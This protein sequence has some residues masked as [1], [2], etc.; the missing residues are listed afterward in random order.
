MSIKNFSKRPVFLSL[1]IIFVFAFVVFV[2]NSA[3]VNEI[4]T[5]EAA[6]S[7]NETQNS[8]L[9]PTMTADN[10]DTLVTDVDG[11]GRVD[12]GDTIQYTVT[13]NNSAGVGVGNDALGVTFSET[14]SNDTTLVGGSLNASPI[15][16]NDT[17][18]V[19]GNLQIQV[20]DGANDVLANDFD[21]DTNSNAGLTASGGTTSAQGGNVTINANGSF[22]Y[23]PPPGFEGTDTFTYTVTD[24]GGATNTATIT[25]NVSG[26]IWFVNNNA[27]ACT[28]LAAGCGRLTNPFS[29]LAAFVALNNGT[30]N[31]PAANDN[32]FIFESATAYTGGVTL[33]SGQKLI[34]QD[35]TATLSAISGIMPAMFS[36]AL[37]AMNTGGNASTI[38]NAA[39]NGVTLGSG[40]AIRGFTAS[41]SSS[42]SISGSSFGT[43]TIADVIINTNAQAL[44][45]TTGTV[46]G[47]GFNSITSTGGAR[48]ISLTG[49]LGTLN[50]GGG[51]L[52]GA[53]GEAFFVSG[54]TGA[55]DYDGTFTKSSTGSII[56]ITAHSGGTIDLSGNISCTGSCGN[57]INIGSNTGG[58]INLGGATKTISTGANPAVLLQTNTGTTINFSNGGLDIDTTSGTGFTATGGGTINVTT[59]ANPNT[60]DS[61]TGTALNVANTTIGASG[62]TFRSI[63][64][65]GGTNNGIILNN[66]GSGAF[67][68]TG[69]GGAG[70]GGTLQNIVGADAVSLNTTGGL[71]T[72][73]S[74]IIQDITASTDATDALQT[75]TGVDAIHGRTI[76]GGL[77]M[78][79]STIQRI[80]D[81]AING[82]VDAVPVTSS[83][84]A[85]TWSGLT[86]TNSTFQNTNRF[87]VAGRGD[88]TNESA[89]IIWGIKGTVSITGSTFQNC[90]SGID[91]RTD[92][93]GTLD[94]TAQ[95]NTFNTLYKEIGTNSV[96]RFGISVVQLGSVT[97][98]VRVGDWQNE[99][100]AVLGNTFTNGGNVAGIQIVS[101]TDSTGNLKAEVAKNTFT[102][103]DHSSPGQPPLN[104]I[105]NFPQSGVLYRNL[106]S[107][108]FEGI[109]AANIF[110]QAMHANG[111]LGQL[112]LIAEKGDSEFIVRN[113]T[114]GLPWDLP[115][116]IR[117]DGQLGQNSCKV[118]ITGNTHIDGIVG[119]GTTDLGGQS[120]YGSSYVQ[121]R[122]N[123]R[124]DLTLQNEAT[125]LGLTD[126]SSATGSASLYV[127][128]TSAG[129]IL[130]L[131]M[132]NIQGPR[133]Y[134]LIQSAGTTFNLF[135]NGSG[136][137]T[138]QTVLQDNNN[139]GGG[140]VDTTNPPTV[141]ATGTITLSNTAP[142]LPNIT[143]SIAP[144]S[145]SGES[146]TI[147]NLSLPLNS[148]QTPSEILAMLEPF[149]EYSATTDTI[150][151]QAEIKDRN[152]SVNETVSSDDNEARR[153]HTPLDSSISAF[154]SELA[155]KFTEAISPTVYSQE[156]AKTE[157]AN[158]SGETVTV[159]G[160]GGGFTLPA[161]KSVT[162]T[163][164]AT[165]NNTPIGLTQVQTQ[166]TVSGSNFSNV[167]TNDPAT[168]TA[169]DATVTLIDSTTVTVSSSQNPSITGQSVTFT[170]TLTGAPV[171]A[172]GDPSGT[173]QF[174]DNGVA[175]GAPQTV[176]AG[177]ANDNTGTATFTTSSLTEGSHPIT[178]TFSGGGGFNAN[179]TSNTLNQTVGNTAVWDGSASA[180]WN[181]AAN[182]TTNGVPSLVTHD[183]SIPAAGVINNPTISASD[184]SVN[185]L[186]LAAGR[187][188]TINSNRTL[189]IAGVLTMN[190]NNIDASNGVLALGTGATIVR[191]SGS[192]L[193][194][195]DKSFAATGAFVYH[196][197]TA[198]GYSPVN[199]NITALA[200]NPS[201]LR[202]RANDG[203]APATPPIA[204]ATSLDR[205]WTL[206][207]TGD[208]T[209]NVVFNYLTADVDGNEN[210]YRVFRVIGATAVGFPNAP[211]CP[212]AGS[213]CVDPGVNTITVNGL[214]T[215][216]NW[217]AGELAP[218]AA[219][220]AVGGR[221]FDAEGR[222][223]ARA[224]IILIDANGNIRTARSNPF[225]YYRFEDVETGAN[226]TINIT[227][228]QYQFTPQI[229]SVTEDLQELN[230]TALPE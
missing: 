23:N 67:T 190:G 19:T 164:R 39:G 27:A 30:G 215:F 38:Q 98:T 224:E 120:P 66:A 171:H 36:D 70:S 174:F 182:W 34:G 153:S 13:I 198:T 63:A 87:N 223:V 31:N 168:G 69:T 84:T 47:A 24:A 219:N 201:T 28:T 44:S 195:F 101:D 88:A 146:K 200:T 25:F 10:N 6:A 55:L 46:A 81:N 212:G 114:F 105:Y 214:Q 103:T 15:A 221:I 4:F 179:N 48:N 40:N 12:P 128:T 121:V 148:Y 22:S 227:H 187:T 91:F 152:A 163:F 130:N 64:K 99:T 33:L 89:I 188:L 77:T 2:Q 68:V 62:L 217:T 51:A 144:I 137:G 192:V 104:T 17:F 151:A 150:I 117:A 49:V 178:A 180:D 131:F 175:L 166:G 126:T 206:T 90:S 124:M 143:P 205:Y 75:H 100:N 92:T 155:D 177:A 208:L 230:F 132:Q 29:T 5:T 14:L 140:G 154:L 73:N 45:L 161:T 185:N 56:L 61:T 196:V 16:G 194:N 220:V 72:L 50:M 79:N 183:V 213:P 71:V 94:M 203:T 199:V 82:T 93:S 54:G 37:P 18:A 159:N 21:P 122:N 26:M 202:V 165:V 139:R 112:S 85:T 97:S 3:F 108:N 123:G 52:S 58:T 210:N 197:G 111:G 225:G 218:V 96:G 35:A 156:T 7:K 76:N 9:L 1:S 142:M 107:G 41:N 216:S 186:T 95:S 209:A 53:T 118:L 60:I 173:V 149:I 78:T 211:P 189:N 113:N 176:S 32:I 43:V 147:G 207:E 74:M 160:A 228:K 133:G 204:D 191:T 110:D 181:T 86:I 226:Y 57:G 129:D 106:G 138:A 102:V 136:G 141:T 42:S 125:P 115:M 229:I 127:Q 222:A 184:V 59:G 169:N 135:R 134:R 167:L 8:L 170:A 162:I 80:S 158:I 172:T 109:F 83:P 20:P 11:D 157:V 193:G 145:E 119:D 116:E 65:N